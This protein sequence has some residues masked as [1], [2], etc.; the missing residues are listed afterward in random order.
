MTC[1]FCS[2][3]LPE[4]AN[5]CSHCGKHQISGAT[6]SVSKPKQTGL[7]WKIALSIVLGIVLLGLI[8]GLL[9]QQGAKQPAKPGR[10]EET[11]NCNDY[12]RRLKASFYNHGLD[13]EV[14]PMTQGTFQIWGSAVDLAFTQAMLQPEALAA[15][16]QAHCHQ[17]E[18]VNTDEGRAFVEAYEIGSTEVP[19]VAR[20]RHNAKT[21][22]WELPEE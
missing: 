5:F 13:V 7:A 9:N 20:L 18:F 4:G 19:L 12:A 21:K 16:R 8:G 15:M 6:V 22:K 14:L 3:Q 11:I 2:R 17:I 10:Q 1:K